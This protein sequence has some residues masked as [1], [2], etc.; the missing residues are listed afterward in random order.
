MSLETKPRRSK[1]ELVEFATSL[2]Y[3]LNVRQAAAEALYQ[4]GRVDAA[5]ELSAVLA[6]PADVPTVQS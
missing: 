5:N 3:P 1:D 2:A 6:R 4:R